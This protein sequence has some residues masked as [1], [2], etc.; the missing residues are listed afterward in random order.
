MCVC[1]IFVI[2][3]QQLLADFV[4]FFAHVC[5]YA[6][7]S[8]DGDSSSSFCDESPTSIATSPLPPHLSLNIYLFI[9]FIAMHV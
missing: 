4:M 8:F 2:Q 6:T 9:Q 5:N 7:A 3:M 1:V